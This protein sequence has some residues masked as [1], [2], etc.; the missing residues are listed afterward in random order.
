MS[1]ACGDGWATQAA[2]RGA[3]GP[4]SSF[5]SIRVGA[6]S[7]AAPALPRDTSTALDEQGAQQ[8]LPNTAGARACRQGHA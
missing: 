1:A 3:S 2:W 8:H 6:A 7:G 5:R 4:L